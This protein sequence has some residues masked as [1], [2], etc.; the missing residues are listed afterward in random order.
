MNALVVARRADGTLLPGSKLNSSGR[1]I[2]AI[3][4]VRA[5]LGEHAP[6]IVDTLLALLSSED[7]RVRLAAVSVALDRLCGRPAP[8]VD[9]DAS[10]TWA[11]SVQQLYLRA[12]IEANRNHTIDITPAPEERQTADPGEEW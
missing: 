2:S 10:Q 1:P 6:Q 3:A 5:L 4:E 7:E 12:V 8:A 9:V 11:A